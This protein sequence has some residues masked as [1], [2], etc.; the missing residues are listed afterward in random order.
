MN[1]DQIYMNMVLEYAKFSKCQFTQVSSM[2]VNET[3]R[4]V[5][6]GVNGTIP[7]AQN[8]CEMKFDQRE[9]HLDY[10]NKYE[11]H[12]E[13]NALLELIRSGT[14]LSGNYTMYVSLSPC[15]N[16]LKH[17]AAVQSSKFKINRIVYNQRYHRLTNQDINSMIDFCYDLG[18]ELQQIEELTQ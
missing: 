10:S 3:G 8:C 2:I 1:K 17:I 11:I 18:I 5:S 13:M 14:Q 12:S 15:W 7:N 16:C 4:I 6:T 9:D